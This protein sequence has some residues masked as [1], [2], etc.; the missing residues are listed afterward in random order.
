[1]L[2]KTLDIDQK[3]NH[4]PLP[5]LALASAITGLILSVNVKLT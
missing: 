1:M 5:A 4:S 3:A 2:V